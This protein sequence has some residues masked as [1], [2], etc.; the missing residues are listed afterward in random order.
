MFDRIFCINLDRRPDKW[1]AFQE[2]CPASILPRVER[3]SG[4]DCNLCPAPV[5]WKA[6]GGAWGCYRSHHA[7]VEL[8]LQQRVESVL[9]L[10]DD[11][12]PA[13]DFDERLAVYS[14]ALPDD[15]RMAY[16]GGQLLHTTRESPRRVNEHVYQPYNVN[17]THAYALRGEGLK[18]VYRHLSDSES[19]KQRHHID[20]HLGVYHEGWPT[21]VYCPAEWIFGQHGG[22]SD[23]NGRE[24]PTEFWPAPAM[25]AGDSGVSIEPS[26]PGEQLPAELAVVLNHAKRIDTPVLRARIRR[27]VER[28][29]KAGRC[30]ALPDHPEVRRA[31]PGVELAAV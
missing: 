16:L 24:K 2:R 7:I 25:E 8:C 27:W 4:I 11:A 3:F 14:S 28:E 10:E 19:W 23:V 15:W 1:L 29:Q 20:H 6:G 13:E 18:T 5:W 21:G 22:R 31:F 26:D 30:G 12:V 17:R 9:I